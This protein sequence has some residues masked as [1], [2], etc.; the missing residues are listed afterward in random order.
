M[1]SSVPVA[2]KTAV[3]NSNASVVLTQTKTVVTEMQTFSSELDK[4]VKSSTQTMTKLR[5]ETEQ[6][7]AREVETLTTCSSRIDEQLRRIQEALTVV[8]AKDQL[9][10]EALGSV[11]NAVKHAHD[12]TRAV[13]SIWADKLKTS[14]TSMCAEVEKAS[15]SGYQTVRLTS[16]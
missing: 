4:F 15:V 1:H 11:Q 5:A 2:R 7:Q 14:H 8:Q 16:T 10:A 12:Q 6:C 3:S 13:F 9:S